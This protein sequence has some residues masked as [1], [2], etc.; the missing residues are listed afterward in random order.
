M[1]SIPILDASSFI[2]FSLLFNESARTNFLSG[3]TIARGIPGNP[4]PVPISI[5][6]SASMYSLK[7]YERTESTKCLL[8]NSSLSV[9][10]VRLIFLFH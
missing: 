8:M 1:L 9:I 7:L 6:E 5:I 3:L 2:T 4:A 10:A